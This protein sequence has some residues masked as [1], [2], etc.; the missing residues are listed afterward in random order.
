MKYEIN[1]AHVVHYTKVPERKKNILKA[2][3]N[4]NVDLQ[5]VEI[6]DQ[7]DLDENILNKF[8]RQ[9]KESF[10]S[11]IAPLWGF[12]MG[13][14]NRFRVLNLAEISCTLKHIEAIRRVAYGEDEIG[15]ILEDDAIPT[16]ENFLEE[17]KG[18]LKRSG[19][20][21]DSISF[22][23]GCGM[24]FIRSKLE[25]GYVHA[26]PDL[27]KVAHPATNC[28]EAYLVK[29]AAAQKLYNAIVPFDLVSDWEIAYH[30]YNLDMEVYWCVNPLFYQGSKSG[31]YKSTLR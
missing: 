6:Y 29:K 20:Q 24:S 1:K 31:L 18:I 7:E 28:A 2:F 14:E 22:G 30:F 9:D 10:E 19:D 25:Q 23:S 26:S 13:N 27:V 4:E 5:F 16:S 15:L 17:M 12:G 11:K 21:W 8:Y 3:H